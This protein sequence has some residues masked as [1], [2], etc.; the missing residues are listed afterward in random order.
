M[1]ILPPDDL[2]LLNY[3]LDDK[4]QLEYTLILVTE[5]CHTI[6]LARN[7]K[8]FNNKDTTEQALV[9]KFKYKIAMRIKCD[10]YRMQRTKFKESWLDKTIKMSID[11]KNTKAIISTF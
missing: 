6:W 1:S 7:Q 10:F 2:V 8:V 9:A 5:A 3:T 11:E 4:R